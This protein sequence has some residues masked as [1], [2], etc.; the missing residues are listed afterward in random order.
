MIRKATR[1][2]TGATVSSLIGMYVAQASVGKALIRDEVR[3]RRFYIENITRY[4]RL[5]LKTMNFEVEAVGYEGKFDGGKNYLIVSN[6]MSYIDILCLSSVHSAM[7]VTSKDMG[8]NLFLGTLAEL[9]GSVFVERRHRAHVERDL[10]Q[11]ST[12]LQQGFDV[13]L[14]P[15]G[16]S[17]NGQG[18]LPF[19]KSLLMAAVEAGVDI[20]PMTI[21][22]THI[23]DQEFSSE[24]ADQV[25]WYGDMDFAPHL[26]GLFGVDSVKARLEFLEP[27]PVTKDSSR[28]DLAGQA[29]RAIVENYGS[30]A[31]G[32]MASRP[33]SAPAADGTSGTSRS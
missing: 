32:E 16:T 15:E 3:R 12:A 31:Q 28:H 14:Y 29:Y 6:H 24:N 7:F 22:Y 10:T 11:I 27:I 1:V 13:C 19:K 33:N 25:C 18:V 8:E 4:A 17:S 21:K 30:S 5:A 26:L 23:N 2:L 9:G 20:L